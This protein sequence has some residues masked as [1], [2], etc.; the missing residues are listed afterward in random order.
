MDGRLNKQ[1]FRFLVCVVAF[2]LMSGLKP[3]N[4]I[5]RSPFDETA[6]NAFSSFTRSREE[7]GNRILGGV[8]PHHEIALGMMLHF[9]DRF[10]AQK[11][12]RVFLFS[13]DHFKQV[14]GWAAVCA[15]GWET[16][17]RT[18][19][20]DES[21]IA[22]LV[23]TNIALENSQIFAAEHGITIHIPLVAR[24]F[25]NA[26]VVPVLL[27]HDIP[28]MAVLSLRKA[29]MSVMR[30][31]DVVILS[32]DLSH[33]KTPE[34]MAAEDKRTLAVLTGMSVAATGSIDADAG[35]ASSLVMLVLR[36]MGARSG[37]LIERTDSSSILGK[38]FESGTSYATIIYRL[39]E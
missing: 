34:A 5:L 21:A 1:S 18:L 27:R 36:D 39:D 20:S 22:A 17:S 25:P 32:M 16:S 28:D 2:A 14:T 3:A 7:S 37:E 23:G 30:E 26:A 35:R 9:Y 15:D 19:H 12:E 10:P 24:F 11:V 38:R 29:L 33:Y 4:A 13:P 31:G 6:G 8:V